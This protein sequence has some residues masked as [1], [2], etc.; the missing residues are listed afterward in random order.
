MVPLPW[1]PVQ[2]EELVQLV[3]PVQLVGLG[4]LVQLVQLVQLV[5]LGMAHRPP[6]MRESNRHVQFFLFSSGSISRLM[7]LWAWFWCCRQSFF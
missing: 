2:M 5:G 3:Q 1:P 6:I 7:G 4:L